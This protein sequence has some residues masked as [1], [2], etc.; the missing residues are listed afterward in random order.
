MKARKYAFGGDVYA[1]DQMT[2]N[3]YPFAS[4]PTNNVD[5][6]AQQNDLDQNMDTALNQYR[7]GGKV[8]GYAKGGAIRGGGCEQRGK[9]KGRFV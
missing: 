8:K 1:P 5:V 9:T 4:Q 6:R 2:P 3:T 7:K